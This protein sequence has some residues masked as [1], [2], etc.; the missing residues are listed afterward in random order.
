[1]IDQPTYQKRTKDFLRRGGVIIRGEDAKRHS[2][3]SGAYASYVTGGNFAFI[4]D[5]ATVSDVL[6]EMYHAE[7][8]RKHKFS[9]YPEREIILRR[10]IG[11]Q[12]CLLSVSKRYK[13][14]LEEIKVTTENLK[15]YERILEEILR[16]KERR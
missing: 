12:K 11:A 15:R 5:D 3:A 4:R 6:E 7:Q 9:E 13:I 10:E 2:D 14:S 8:D 1:M 16:E